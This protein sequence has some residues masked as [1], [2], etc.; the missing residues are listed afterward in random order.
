MRMM[1]QFWIT[2]QAR[3]LASLLAFS[4]GILLG[5]TTYAI[6]VGGTILALL[7]IGIVV[8]KRQFRVILLLVLLCFFVGETRSL[9]ED[10]RLTANRNK[11]SSLTFPREMKIV[12]FPTNAVGSSF[13]AE[14]A[15]LH[16]RLA[17]TTTSP[18]NAS[19]GDVVIVSGGITPFSDVPVS[20]R[21]Y[22]RAHNIAGTM[23]VTNVR[24]TTHT[25]Y[26]FWSMLTTLRENISLRI[27]RLLPQREG[28][29]LTALL[30][31]TS[32]IPADMG[33][34]FRTSGLQHIIAVSGT[35]VSILAVCL[36]FV[37][38]ALGV[39]R[40]LT[41]GA[42]LILLSC[43]I[44]LV[45]APAS[46]VRAGVMAATGIFAMAL[47]R[48]AHAIRL[49]LYAVVGIALVSPLA[50]L[51]DVG[52]QL[53]AMAMLGMIVISPRIEKRMP[54]VFPEWLSTL[55]SVTLGAQ[56][57]TLPVLVSTF[58]RVS[59]YGL[60][61]NILTVPLT[62]LLF[63]FSGLLLSAL[64]LPFSFAFAI[65]LPARLLAGYIIAVA[66][67]AATLP[68]ASVR[69]TPSF[70]VTALLYGIVFAPVVKD[71]LLAFTE[72]EE[73]DRLETKMK[74]VEHSM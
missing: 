12:S 30:L 7:A 49:L 59:L 14:D 22:L 13:I 73:N 64:A 68:Y 11:I 58:E 45:G 33:A 53:S 41:H 44:V 34:D 27:A 55:L 28:A 4:G 70:F 51:G 48:R 72:V 2:T 74:N 35:H 1:Q 31:G 18:T 40:T 46:A 43:Y 69:Y 52:L 15:A 57:A 71:L 67:A 37:A 19:R 39:Y 54:R 24:V 56:I 63:A 20:Y 38:R 60:F 10:A 21:N 8:T 42:L 65:S 25:P 36:W 32:T 62:P 26:S 47:R 17:L 6:P 5:G 61:A 29:F 50:L 3:L 9:F 23:R 16:I 66:H